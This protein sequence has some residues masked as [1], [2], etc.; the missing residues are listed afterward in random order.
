MNDRRFTLAKSALP[1]RISLPS[2]R[3]VRISLPSALPVRISALRTL[4]E[5]ITLPPLPVRVPLPGTTAIA[6]PIVLGVAV[7]SAVSVAAP[8]PAR[9]AADNL[10]ELKP[11]VMTYTN[12]AAPNTVYNDAADTVLSASQYATYLTFDT[13][14]LPATST[15]VAAE[16]QVT[17]TTSRATRPA[18]S[19]V[20]AAPTLAD[21]AMTYQKMTYATRPAVISGTL[22]PERKGCRLGGQDLDDQADRSVGVQATG[23]TRPEAQLYGAG[24][25][26]ESIQ[27]DPAR[28]APAAQGQPEWLKHLRGR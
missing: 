24:F 20:S 16:L 6:V 21:P 17:V 12:K 22:N 3:P 18:L 8:T 11:A 26:R 10:I 4:P 9:A 25:G 27:V 28:A 5:R 23:L 7:A 13:S 15:I 2:A 1:V 14:K 19:V